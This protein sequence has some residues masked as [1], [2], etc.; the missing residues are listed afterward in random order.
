MT[1]YVVDD[2]KT[3]IDRAKRDFDTLRMS[4]SA[5]EH[6]VCR[7]IEHARAATDVLGTE[8]LLAYFE[9]PESKQDPDALDLLNNLVE[10]FN[11]MKAAPSDSVASVRLSTPLSLPL[12]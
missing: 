3:A 7:A 9:P 10:S 5:V 2:L 12:Y 1:K 4:V 11:W 8:G 6:S